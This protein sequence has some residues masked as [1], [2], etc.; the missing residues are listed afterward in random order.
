MTNLA[1]HAHVHTASGVLSHALPASHAVAR[2]HVVQLR[3]R[4]VSSMVWQMQSEVWSI[5]PDLGQT[6]TP[7]SVRTAPPGIGRLDPFSRVYSRHGAL[8]M[9]G[10]PAV[11]RPVNH[12]LSRCWSCTVLH[13]TYL[14]MP[15]QLSSAEGVSTDS[16][17]GALSGSVYSRV[18]F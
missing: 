9:P 2:A 10:N 17:N 3:M 18:L 14:D 8:H 13:V 7:L 12:A 4:Y 15:S 5:A 6:A 1:A 16:A 11:R